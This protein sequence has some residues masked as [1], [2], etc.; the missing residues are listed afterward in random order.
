M[1][2]I[3]IKTGIMIPAEGILRKLLRRLPAFKQ[4]TILFVG[5]T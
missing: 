1:V 2:D 4:G 3:N 5:N